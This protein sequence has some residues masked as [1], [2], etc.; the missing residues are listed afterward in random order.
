MNLFKKYR[1]IEVKEKFIAQKKECLFFNIWDGISEKDFYLWF[2]FEYQFQYCSF[3][4][5]EEAR[6][7]L[8]NYKEFIKKPKIKYYYDNE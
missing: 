7:H 4:T 3:G 8:K 6:Q 5:L 2:A 1:I